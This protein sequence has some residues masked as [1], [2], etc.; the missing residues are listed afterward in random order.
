MAKDSLWT[1]VPNFSKYAITK[2]GV[3]KNK[4][5]G[6][7]L[8]THIGKTGWKS[9]WL[10]KDTEPGKYL[11]VSRSID[12]LLKATFPMPKPSELP[13]YSVIRDRLSDQVYVQHKDYAWW[14]IEYH[15][16]DCVEFDVL[17]GDLADERLWLYEL[18]AKPEGS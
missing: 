4:R 10:Y 16:V 5:T 7:I 13:I 3:I 12:D 2:E 18:I 14:P 11:K 17:E 9:V 6:R 8:T 15:C 1:T